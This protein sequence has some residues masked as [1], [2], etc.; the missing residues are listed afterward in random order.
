MKEL[1]DEFKR[2]KAIDP[3]DIAEKLTGRSADNADVSL[4]VAMPL[5]HEVQRQKKDLAILTDD[6]YFSMPMKD[7]KSTLKRMGFELVLEDPLDEGNFYRIWWHK[8]GFIISSDSYWGDKS[9][10]GG[11]MYFSFEPN[12]KYW[13]EGCSGGGGTHMYSYDIREGL[14]AKI[15][16]LR[17]NGKFL[18]PWNQF[19]F[20]WLLSYMDTKVEGYDFK[21]ITAARIARLPQEVQDC[22]LTNK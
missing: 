7:F 22:I 2:L 16:D 19:P 1:R 20:L 14:R 17:E 8:D 4:G 5:M 11:N 15:E 3:I 10:N 12:K 21:A 18:N 13:V 6:T 9:V